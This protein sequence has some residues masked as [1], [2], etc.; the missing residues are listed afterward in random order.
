MLD[1][2]NPKWKGEVAEQA[3]ATEL[4]KRGLSVSRPLGD[5][6]RY[7]L[8]LDYEQKIWRIQ[9]KHLASSN[10]FATAS[11][12]SN[13][14]GFVRSG[15]HGQVDLFMVWSMVEPLKVFVVPVEEATKGFMTLSF[16][17]VRNCMI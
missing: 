7:D 5:S 10:S 3:I 2:P 1:K 15:Y 12:R 11:V 9:C 13:S 6:Q 4:M 8:L 16:A 14:T 17:R